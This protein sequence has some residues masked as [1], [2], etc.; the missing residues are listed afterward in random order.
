MIKYN[1]IDSCHTLTL[2]QKCLKSMRSNRSEANAAEIKIL[3]IIVYYI[4]LSLYALTMSVVT[5]FETDSFISEVKQYF[6]CE[7]NG[8]TAAA[9][10]SKLPLYRFD[11]VSKVFATLLVGVYPVIFL[12]Y[13]VQLK[14]C[15]AKFKS[16]L[17]TVSSYN[18][19]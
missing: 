4:I 14:T 2:L 19:K 15:V 11:S 10:C 9:N 1:Y 3:I 13:I 7:A 8:V 6:L 12:I 16:T 17:T 5:F 18:S